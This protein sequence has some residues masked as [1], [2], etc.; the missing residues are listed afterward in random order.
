MLCN[1]Q[2]CVLEKW[3]CDGISD[4]QDGT[5]ELFCTLCPAGEHSCSTIPNRCLP[6]SWRCDGI[7]DCEDGSDE[8]EC[9]PSLCPE[10]HYSCHSGQKCLPRYAVCNGVVDCVGGDDEDAELCPH[11]GRC[12]KGHIACEDRKQCV[13]W[14]Q[15]CNGRQDC[16]DNSDENN[17]RCPGARMISEQIRIDANDVRNFPVYILRV[18]V[19][20]RAGKR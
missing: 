7:V 5:D 14:F 1:N 10:S 19:S 2:Q 20:S 15:W 13:P 4:C 8:M 16:E 12:E 17:Q 11:G 9:P 3:R 18:L 6:G